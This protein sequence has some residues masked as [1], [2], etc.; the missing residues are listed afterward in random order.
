MS[1]ADMEKP[2]ATVGHDADKMAKLPVVTSRVQPVLVGLGI[3]VTENPAKR[4][5]PVG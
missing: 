3:S 4:T 2:I 5:Q 1:I